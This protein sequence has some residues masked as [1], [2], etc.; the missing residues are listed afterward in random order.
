M[1]NLVIILLVL[2]AKRAEGESAQTIEPFKSTEVTTPQ[3][4]PT[5]QNLGDLNK[6]LGPAPA[7]VSGVVFYFDY[8]KFLEWLIPKKHP[9][10]PP[11]CD[12]KFF[13]NDSIPSSAP[14]YKDTVRV[15]KPP[16]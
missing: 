7:P 9:K 4:A 16:V 2:L 10:I 11:E 5:N 1:K 8:T 3:P 15:T 13:L 14:I 12:P 6:V